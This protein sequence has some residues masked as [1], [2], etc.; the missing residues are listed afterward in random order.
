LAA[1]N[2][3]EG[4]IVDAIGNALYG[5]LTFVNGVPDKDNFNKHRMIRHHEVLKD[6][7]VHF[8]KNDIV[9]TCIGEPA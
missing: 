7:D 3:A 9:R 5:E 8:V 4:S 1:I 2:Q 6:I